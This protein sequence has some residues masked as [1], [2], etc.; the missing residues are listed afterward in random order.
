M[1]QLNM[2]VTQGYTCN[3]TAE[4]HTNTQMNTGVMVKSSC[5]LWILVSKAKFLV[6]MFSPSLYWM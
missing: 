4:L 1:L 6:L 5:I 2:S 3:D